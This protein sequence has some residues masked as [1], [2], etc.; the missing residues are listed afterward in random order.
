MRRRIMRPPMYLC[1]CRGFFVYDVK[2]EFGTLH[3]FS[4]LCNMIAY[5]YKLYR[6]D[7]TK[8]LDRMLSEACFV[9]N[10]ALSL[11]KRYYRLYGKYISDSRMRKHFA[12]RI[13]RNL[14]HS[15]TVQ[16]IIDRLDIAYQRFFEHLAK[17]PPKFRKAKD[18][19]SFVFRQGGYSLN[20]N[21]LT[22]NIIKKR[23]KFS[24]SRP[25]AGKVKTLTV[26]RN[27]LGEFFIV[28]ALD[29][30]PQSIGKTHNGASV[31]ID[32]GLKKYM[33]L[34]DGT[35]VD[36]PQFLKSGLC[37]LQRKSR[38]LSKC[39]PGSHNRERKRLDLDRHHEKV[40]NQ[41]NAFQWQL[42]HRLCQQYDR[43]FI[44]DLRLT[45]MSA[46]W[47]R[48]MADLAHG[49]F[50]LKLQYVAT[51]YGVTVHK[52]DRFYPSSK[53]CTCGYVNHG[54]QLH[55]RTWVCPECGTVHKRDLLAANN[56]LRQGIAELESACKTR[57]AARIPVR[58]RSYSRISRLQ[59]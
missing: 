39:V 32:F 6:T 29:Q 2:R 55:E 33:T 17:R 51:K 50:V 48:K 22:I 21:V 7:K 52:I 23:F 46:M 41:R 53:T 28:M 31:G 8:H 42:A 38:N 25:Y 4:Y 49:A 9:W 47:G 20:G 35:T 36:N 18:F 34:S 19:S 43:I 14:L 16:E 5:K 30:S 57:E 24:L 11:Q 1:V 37:Q 12:K 10:H 59:A 13:K 3:I 26:K 27:N 58:T 54:L 45:G 44:E 40:V 15:Q 56:I